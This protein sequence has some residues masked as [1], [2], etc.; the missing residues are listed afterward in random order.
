[1]EEKEILKAKNCT[2]EINKKTSR[3]KY[4]Y[5]IDLD[6]MIDRL[7]LRMISDKDELEKMVNKAII[8]NPK[9]VKDKAIEVL[10]GK[11][12]KESNGKANPIIVREIIGERWDQE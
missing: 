9:I 2:H 6:H 11:V 8:D 3:C 4:C 5:H 1:M 12:M 7:D 10:I